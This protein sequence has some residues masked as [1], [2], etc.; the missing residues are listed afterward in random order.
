M[1]QAEQTV[2]Q[3]IC[4]VKGATENVR[5]IHL[6]LMAHKKFNKKCR[7]MGIIKYDKTDYR[8]SDVKRIFKDLP[9]STKSPITS[10]RK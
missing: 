4:G 10:K 7:V 6:T 9:G 1:A 8:K 5:K 3:V 2:N